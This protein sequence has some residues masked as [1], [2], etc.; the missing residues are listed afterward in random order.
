MSVYFQEL[1]EVL[2]QQAHLEEIL[3]SCQQEL[4][5]QKEKYQL[6]QVSKI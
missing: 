4:Q 3:F 6:I 1:S 5:T 2:S